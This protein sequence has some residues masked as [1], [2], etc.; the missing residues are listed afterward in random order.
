MRLTLVQLMSSTASAASPVDE[1]DAIGSYLVRGASGTSF[2]SC[3]RGRSGRA[4]WFR[5]NDNHV[6]WHRPQWPHLDI[7]TIL[8]SLTRRSAGLHPT[9]S[10]G[11]GDPL[12]RY[13]RSG[14]RCYRGVPHLAEPSSPTY[15]DH[16]RLRPAGTCP[17]LTIRLRTVSTPNV[18][19]PL[20]LRKSGC[21]LKSG[22]PSPHHQ[23]SASS[24][25]SRS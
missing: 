16:F 21:S 15:A 3:H 2:P 10:L 8:L 24:F 7:R 1:P 22:Y 17:V 4:E 13:R 18:G 20:H 11:M 25:T 5:R 14:S 23:T 9:K 19:R 6:L 12:R